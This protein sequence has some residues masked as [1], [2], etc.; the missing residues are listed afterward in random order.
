M[1]RFSSLLR[2]EHSF[3]KNLFLRLGYL[4][5]YLEVNPS[6][7][8]F[9]E[10]EIIQQEKTESL[11]RGLYVFIVNIFYWKC[12]SPHYSAQYLFIVLPLPTYFH[13]SRVVF[14]LQSA[15]E[16]TKQMTIYF[17]SNLFCS[18]YFI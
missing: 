9:G 18:L 1:K 12:Q 5:R 16:G 7:I 4:S 3:K 14:S 15:L 13:L 11:F 6:K 10:W 2:K 8:L 17:K